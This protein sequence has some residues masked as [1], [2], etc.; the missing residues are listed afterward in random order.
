M[1]V[2]SQWLSGKLLYEYQTIAAMVDIYCKAHHHKPNGKLCEQCAEF[3][4]YA[5]VKLDRCPY[6][7]HKPTCNKCPVH[8]YKADM[9]AQAKEIMIFSGPRMLLPHPIMAIKHLLAERGP[10]PGKPP[11]KASNRHLRKIKID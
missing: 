8:C 7:Q 3:L 10:V 1:A 4:A 6:G 5:E 9:R 2:S 11:E